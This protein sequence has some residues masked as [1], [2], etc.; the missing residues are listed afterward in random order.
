[1]HSH[2]IVDETFSLLLSHRPPV[3]RSAAC[4]TAADTCCGGRMSGSKTSDTPL[5]V[6][7]SAATLSVGSAPATCVWC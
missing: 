3:T 5:V 1:M 2:T 7:I 4:F 6:V